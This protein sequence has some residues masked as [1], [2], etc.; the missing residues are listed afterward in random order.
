MTQLLKH[1]RFAILTLIKFRWAAVKSL[2]RNALSFAEAVLRGIIAQLAWMVHFW[3]MELASLV[4]VLR[5]SKWSLRVLLYLVE[6]TLTFKPTPK[7]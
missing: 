5:L 4:M 1:V 6:H 3:S 7:R 2:V